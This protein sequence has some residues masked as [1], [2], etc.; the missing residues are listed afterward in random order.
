[1]FVRERERS[2]N[3]I[4]RF[5]T[6]QRRP[7][8]F[9]VA[10]NPH[11]AEQFQ[12]AVHSPSPSPKNPHGAEPSLR[13]H[14]APSADTGSDPGSLPSSRP[15][16]SPQDLRP[17]SYQ[18]LSLPSSS[19]NHHPSSSKHAATAESPPPITT[20]KLSPLKPRTYFFFQP[21]SIV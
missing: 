7:V 6:E 1:M 5:L 3:R 17:I 11:G 20:G 16:S 18:K 4:R 12:C 2:V 19:H 8:A 21:P 10:K 13:L 14:I 9:A 15:S